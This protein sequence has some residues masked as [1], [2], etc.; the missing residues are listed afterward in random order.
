[1]KAKVIWVKLKI[2]YKNVCHIRLYSLGITE[3]IY[4][5]NFTVLH[6]HAAGENKLHVMY[7]KKN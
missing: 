7:N 5:E 2:I 6:S 3:Q 1:M 4:E